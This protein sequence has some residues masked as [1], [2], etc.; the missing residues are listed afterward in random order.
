MDIAM[1]VTA[2]VAGTE[3]G[4]VYNPVESMEPQPGEQLGEVVEI[5][6]VAVAWATTQVTSFGVLS[7]VR[8]AW[9]GKGEPVDTVAEVGTIVTRIPESKLIVAVPVFCLF[10]LEVAVMVMV[11]GGLGTVAGAV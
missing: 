9:N 6:T 10:S 1:T 5:G 2:A 8:V 3:A 4:A 7:L 11:G